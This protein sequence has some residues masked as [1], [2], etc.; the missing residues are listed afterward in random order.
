[1][2]KSYLAGLFDGEGCVLIGYRKTGNPRFLSMYISITNQDPRPLKACFQE[3]GGGILTR[4]IRPDWPCY[5][6][7]TGSRKALRFLKDVLP[8]LI[9]KKEEAEVAIQFQEKKK[10]GHKR[11]EEEIQVELSLREKLLLIRRQ[12]KISLMELK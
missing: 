6:W 10:K 4:S 8:W 5:R 3:Y 1:M 7:Q 2:E 9:I 12:R 11:S